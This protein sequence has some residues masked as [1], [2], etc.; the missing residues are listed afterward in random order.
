MAIL[1]PLLITVCAVA[2]VVTFIRT[3]EVVRARLVD[4]EVFKLTYQFLLIVVLGS[5]VTV[6]FQAVAVARDAREKRR[7]MQREI[8][9]A[10]VQAYNDAKQA[11]RLLRASVSSGEPHSV[12]NSR[13]VFR[14]YDKQLEAVSRAQLGIELVIRRI[15]FNHTSFKRSDEIVGHLK[16]VEKYLN[17]VIDEWEEVRRNSDTDPPQVVVSELPALDDFLRHYDESAVFGREFKESFAAAL[18]LLEQ[19]VRAG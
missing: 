16:T 18:Q 6:S 8:H 10:L 17:R 7:T 19:A 11:R 2:A 1:A 14:Q 4:P 12:N 3:P 15:R 5:A 13:V 9:D